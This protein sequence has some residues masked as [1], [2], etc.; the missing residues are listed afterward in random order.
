M[1]FNKFTEIVIAVY[2]VQQQKNIILTGEG[3]TLIE[4]VLRAANLHYTDDELQNILFV[5]ADDLTGLKAWYKEQGYVLSEP[6]V[7]KF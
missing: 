4:A 2:D 6:H 7:I 3:F 5:Y 1:A